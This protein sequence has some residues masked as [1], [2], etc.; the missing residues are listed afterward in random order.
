MAIQLQTAFVL[1]AGL[2]TRMRPLTETLPK[3]L[4]RL[5]G[6]TLLDHA[7]DR[8]AAAGI[9]EAVVNVH[10][11]ADQIELH[12]RQRTRAPRTLVSDERA[13]LL[14][15][16]GGVT[17]ALPLLGGRPF[18]IH[19]SDSVWIERGQ[20]NIARLAAA[21]DASHM[22]G[23]LLL[24]DR[25]ASLGYDG[26]GDFR[27]GAD[28]R[29]ARVGKGEEAAFVFAGVSIAGPRLLRD[30]PEGAF[31]L[32]RLWDR[33]LSEGRLHGLVLDGTW[34]HVGDP[35]ALAAAEARMATAAAGTA[36]RGTGDLS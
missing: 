10:Y 11:R 35:K 33:A 19:N 26:R 30:A 36:K 6:R 31:S 8:I 20:G 25:E 12:L 7:L 4:V 29:I 13:L 18:L 17:K 5:A 27:L 9:A 16:G 14:D 23:L 24:A 1:A 32:N 3:P 21:F 28:G 15:T 34:M 22:D 2:G